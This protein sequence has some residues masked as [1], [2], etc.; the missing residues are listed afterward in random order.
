MAFSLST[1][2]AY[3][4]PLLQWMPPLGT[5]PKIRTA[6]YV[7]LDHHY[8]TASW[9]D[10]PKPPL[11]TSLVCRSIPASCMKRWKKKKR[12]RKKKKK[13][14]TELKIYWQDIAKIL[15]LNISESEVEKKKGWKKKMKNG[16]SRNLKWLI[17]IDLVGSS[18]RQYFAPGVSFLVICLLCSS[19]LLSLIWWQAI[20]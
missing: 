6:L 8:T 2:Y 4:G 13:N 12:E 19:V 3:C 1:V 7:N 10:Q 16:M 9:Q 17:W 18:T 15:I 5:S 20:W 14:R 11:T